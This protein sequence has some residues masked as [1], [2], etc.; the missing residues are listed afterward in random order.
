M[1]SCWPAKARIDEGKRMHGTYD[2]ALICLQGHVVNSEM[3][4]SPEHSRSFCDQCGEA[5]ISSCQKCSRPIRGEYHVPGVT[6]VGFGFPAPDYCADCGAAFPWR[7][8][9]LKAAHDLIGELDELSP[10]QRNRLQESLDQLSR[11]TPQT[12]VAATRVKKILLSLGKY[13]AEAV[14]KI[15]IEVASEAAKK[16]IGL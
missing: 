13:S 10:E 4:R 5:T 3:M 6:A 8:A 12:E 2:R 9:K 15:V 1:L 11:D 7:E 16:S 14:R